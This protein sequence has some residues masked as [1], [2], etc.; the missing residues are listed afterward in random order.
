[1]VMLFG[2]GV[3]YVVVMVWSLCYVHGDAVVS[4]DVNWCM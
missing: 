2:D 3:V 1:M 4:V